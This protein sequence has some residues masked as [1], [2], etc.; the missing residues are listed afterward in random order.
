MKEIYDNP[1][2]YA[3]ILAQVAADAVSEKLNKI[4][5]KTGED[6]AFYGFRI[7]FDFSLLSNGFDK[8]EQTIRVTETHNW[9]Y[10]EGIIVKKLMEAEGGEDENLRA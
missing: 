8:I 3:G 10:P 9:N 4:A 2:E 6:A 1:Y 7:I 5:D